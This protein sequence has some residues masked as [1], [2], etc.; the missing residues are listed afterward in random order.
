MAELVATTRLLHH[1]TPIAAGELFEIDD[2]AA[3]TLIAEGSAVDAADVA[4]VDDAPKKGRR[5]KAE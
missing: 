1:G 2:A 5:G 4:A 3:A